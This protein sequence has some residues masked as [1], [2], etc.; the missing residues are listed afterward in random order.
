MGHSP[1]STTEN[2]Y[3]HEVVAFQQ[4]AAARLDSLISGVVKEAVAIGS[5]PQRCHKTTRQ[6]EKAP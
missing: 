3:L 5:V 1:I 2:I 6:K 4:D